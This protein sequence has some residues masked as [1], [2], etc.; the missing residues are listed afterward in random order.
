MSRMPMIRI[1]RPE[2]APDAGGVDRE[3]ARSLCRER[4]VAAG[5]ESHEISQFDYEQAKQE[6]TGE[7]DPDRQ[8][9]I[10]NAGPAGR[11]SLVN[12]PEIP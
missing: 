8:D 2:S 7:S 6:L 12:P 5:R 10:F 9:A 4:A 1:G 11:T 3:R